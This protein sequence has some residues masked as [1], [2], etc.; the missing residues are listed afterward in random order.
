MSKSFKI[1]VC[2]DLDYEQLIAEIY[3]EEKFVALVSQEEGPSSL[4]LEF[5]G[6]NQ[7][8]EAIIRRVDLKGFQ[9]ALEAAKNKLVE[10][11]S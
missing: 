10:G 11:S 5:P 7:N 1:V 3:Y 9:E 8:E 4:K 6:Q 2:S